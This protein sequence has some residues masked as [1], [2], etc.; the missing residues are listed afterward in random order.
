MT[1][2]DS[3]I[4]KKGR[5]PSRRKKRGGERKN[6]RVYEPQA[7]MFQ[8][9]GGTPLL[10][11]EAQAALPLVPLRDLVVFPHIVAPLFIG[12]KRS[13]AAVQHA[14][15]TNQPII[16]VAQRSATVDYPEPRDLYRTGTLTRVI[17]SLRAP[18]GTMKIF[19]DAQCRTRLREIRT[20]G[21][22]LT[23]VTEDIIEPVM[24]NPEAQ[25]L[26]RLLMERFER[27]LELNPALPEKVSTLL[28]DSEW[29]GQTVDIIAAH[30][31]IR[32]SRRQALLEIAEPMARAL[33][34]VEVLDTEVQILEI[35]KN[36]DS[37]VRD[38]ISKTQKDFYLK[39]QLRAIEEELGE[40]D[41]ERCELRELKRRILEAK[42]SPE[43]EKEALL[44]HAKLARTPSISPQAAVHRNYID[45]LVSLPWNKKT[46]DNLDIAHAAKILDEDH[47]GLEKP[48]ERILEYLAVRRLTDRMKGPILCFIGPPGVGKTSLARSIARAMGRKF[49]RQSLG[50]VRDEAEVRG[51]RRTYIGALPGRVIQGLKKA[52]TRN[53]VFLLDEID[54]LAGDFRGDPAAAL[55]EVLD[56]EENHSFS[57]H[58]LEVEFDLSDVFFIC[59][60]NLESAIPHVLRDRTEVIRLPGYTEMEKVEIARRH[61]IP[62]QLERHGLDGYK[63][64]IDKGA[65]DMLIHQYTHEAGV[66]G[67]EKQLASLFRKTAKEIVE[68]ED[69][70]PRSGKGH[71]RAKTR[72]AF[73]ITAG[74]IEKYLGVPRFRESP[75]EADSGVGIAT[76]LAWTEAGG[77]ILSIEVTRM[78]GKGRLTLTGKLGD[79]MQESARAA[80][81]YARAHAVRFGM[82]KDF[83]E[84]TDVHVHVP[85]G[86]IPKDGPSAGLPISAALVSAL[87]GEPIR[88]DIALTGEI[89]LRGRVLPV[90]GVKE[91]ILAAHRESIYTVILPREN[92]K[93]LKDIP[94]EVQKKMRFIFVDEID[95]VFPKLFLR[96]RRISRMTLDGEDLAPPV[97]H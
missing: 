84:T 4:G 35:Q 13:I 34:L 17:Q 31:T 1:K 95:R 92:R 59:T 16:V 39:E 97:T 44:E 68:L 87:T 6:A 33:A 91:K 89:T 23:A 5:K 79:V 41:P 46:R 20:D 96:R 56:P 82:A 22:F 93:D 54:K 47:Y 49:V 15:K 48:K 77:T 73:K 74:N 94:E 19:V 42:M 21:D 27:Y 83:Y 63:I 53:P 3:K 28:S 37:Q 7:L 12:R 86:A 36:I 78:P 2:R 66:R 55:L 24:D 88:R 50:G 90:G 52:A 71:R 29:L 75:I 58:Y 9:S 72:K 45:W 10:E 18:D 76:G 25:A 69:R 11:D 57:D 81:S 67:L 64:T 60:A 32:L 85:E 51:H 30:V 14:T 43:A 62:K 26:E 70:K 38:K 40:A 80:L 8:T 61:L 65:M